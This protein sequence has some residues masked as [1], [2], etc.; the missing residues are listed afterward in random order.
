MLTHHKLHSQELAKIEVASP[1]LLEACAMRAGIARASPG[2]AWGTGPWWGFFN[3]LGGT[4]TTGCRKVLRAASF[5]KQTCDCP[6]LN[7]Q[8]PGHEMQS[9]LA[10]TIVAEAAPAQKSKSVC[11]LLW[12]VC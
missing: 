11:T 2:P 9:A 12:G 3:F 6:A 1:A 10:L 4:S 7:L 5:L 8:L